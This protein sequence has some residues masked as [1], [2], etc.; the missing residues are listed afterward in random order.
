MNSFKQNIISSFKNEL[1]FVKLMTA[2]WLLCLIPS[3][4]ATQTILIRENDTYEYEGSLYKYGALENILKT[5][6]RAYRLFLKS[7]RAKKAS[8]GLGTS[9]LMCGVLGASLISG[10]SNCSGFLCGIGEGVAGIGLLGAG[11]LLGISAIVVT[12]NGSDRKKESIDVFNR[13]RTIIENKD[14]GTLEL[15]VGPQGIGF[16][17]RF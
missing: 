17:V 8:M 2:V 11:T 10:S 7:R 13:D 12:I 6:D 9:A 4:I 5:N 3:G 14:L 1:T 15:S 16:F